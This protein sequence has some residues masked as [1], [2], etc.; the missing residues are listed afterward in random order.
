M[1]KTT[2]LKERKERGESGFFIDARLQYIL[3]NGK[4]HSEDSPALIYTL[5]EMKCWYWNDLLHR[6]DGPAVTI[7]GGTHEEWWW[8]NVIARNKIEWENKEF[9]K[10]AEI[11]TFL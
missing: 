6:E 8:F 2:L 11:K 3:K 5:M 4:L 9:R 1:F 7:E 10:A